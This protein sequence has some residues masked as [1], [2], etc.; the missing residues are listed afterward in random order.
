MK[1]K[2]WLI[3][4]NIAAFVFLIL[5]LWNILADAVDFINIAIPCLILFGSNLYCLRKLPDADA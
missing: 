5:S 2:S 1:K 4:I 3:V